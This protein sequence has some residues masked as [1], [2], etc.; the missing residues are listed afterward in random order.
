[1]GL[2]DEDKSVVAAVDLGSNS[3][4][5]VIGRFVERELQILDRMRE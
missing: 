4:H 3:F 1:V 5:M 2:S